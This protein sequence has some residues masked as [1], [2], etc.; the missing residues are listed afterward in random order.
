MSW[1]E[2]LY[3]LAAS[4]VAL[5]RVQKGTQATTN[6]LA[7]V[8]AAVEST[9]PFTVSGFISLALMQAGDT[10]LVIE[11]IRDQDDLTYVQYGSVSY[12]GVQSSPMVWFNQKATQGWRIRIQRTA[13]ADRNITYQF[14]KQ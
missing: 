4:I 9:S 12:S 10:F 11:E 8:G 5:A 6:A 2:T 13:G 1:V 14:F 3:N 7:V